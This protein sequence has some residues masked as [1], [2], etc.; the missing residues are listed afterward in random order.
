MGQFKNNTLYITDG[1]HRVVAA[2]IKGMQT[3]D[4]SILQKLID[5]GFALKTISNV[6]SSGLSFSKFPIKWW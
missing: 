6:N 3:G 1:H 2:T 5:N 4:Y